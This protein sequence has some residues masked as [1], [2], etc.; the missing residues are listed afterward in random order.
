VAPLP[1]VLI[2]QKRIDKTAAKLQIERPLIQTPSKI[3]F[4]R[5]AREAFLH[6]NMEKTRKKKSSLREAFRFFQSISETYAFC[7]LKKSTHMIWRLTPAMTKDPPHY[8]PHIVYR[9]LH[10]ALPRLT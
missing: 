7:G 9:A 6:L 2:R 3:R 10:L 5:C 4:A 1:C 8:P